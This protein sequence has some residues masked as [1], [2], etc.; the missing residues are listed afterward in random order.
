SFLVSCILQI[1]ALAPEVTAAYGRLYAALAV[2]ALLIMLSGGGT[3]IAGFTSYFTDVDDQEWWARVGAWVLI[4]S[5]GWSACHLLVLFGPRV[6]VEA[7]ALLLQQSWTWA[8][9]KGVAATLVGIVSGAISLF[10]GYSSETPAHGSDENGE[11]PRSSAL[12][13]LVLPI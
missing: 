5:L 12:A 10:G 3:L 2:P 9:L 4:V 7:Q 6:F 13:A 1:K 11:Q 8:S